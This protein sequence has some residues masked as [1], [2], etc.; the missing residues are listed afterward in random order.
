MGDC[1]LLLGFGEPV[2]NR[3]PCR[4]GRPSSTASRI[5]TPVAMERQSALTIY[6]LLSTAIFTSLLAYI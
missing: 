3:C 1:P 5:Q 4:A 6:Y 2:E